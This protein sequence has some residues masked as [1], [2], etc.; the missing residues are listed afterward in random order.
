MA[1]PLVALAAAFY[2]TSGIKSMYKSTAKLGTGYTTNDHIKITDERFNLREADVKFNNLISTMKSELV[3]Y[4]LSYELI[5]HDLTNEVPYRQL[6][7][8]DEN[9]IVL[10]EQDRKRFLEILEKKSNDMQLLSTFDPEENKLIDFMMNYGYLNWQLTEK[11][12]IKRVKN[13]DY[14]TVQFVSENPILSA[15]VV[16]QLSEEYIRYDNSLKENRSG[17]SVTFFKGL[18]DEKKE[19]LD[20]K[21]KALDEYKSSNN[22]TAS[23]ALGGSAVAQIS[24]YEIRRDELN[25]EIQKLNVLIS[26]V[27]YKLNQSG[28]TESRSSI[29]SKI[30]SIKGKI[31]EL[32]NMYN[33]KGGND[34]EL[35]T[36]ID[37]LRYDLRVQMDKLSQMDKNGPATDK[38]YLQG[39]LEKYKLQLRIA[40]TNVSSVNSSIAGLRGGISGMAS[41]EVELNT[42]TQEVDRAREEYLEAQNRYNTERSKS[43]V[44]QSSVQVVVKGQ[45]N[46]NPERSK[47]FILVALAGVASF[48]LCAFVIILL[49]FVDSRLK[50][51][52]YFK[53]FVGLDLL[54]SINQVNLKNLDLK[55][56]FKKKNENEDI[57]TF[58]HFL[59]KLRFELESSDDKKI[60]VTSTKKGEGK[61][62][63]ILCISYILSMINKRIL[64]IDTNFKNN[65]LTNHLIGSNNKM[66]RLENN[67]NIKRLPTASG[68]ETDE[69]VNPDDDVESIISRTVHQG[70]DIIGNNGGENS[71]SEIFVGKDFNTMLDSLATQY[72]YILLEGASLNDFSDSRELVPFVDLVIPVFSAESAIKQE[73]RE[74]LDYLKALN[75]KLKGGILNKI[76]A[77][78]LK[79]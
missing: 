77:K 5:K 22:I 65:S 41:K 34:A 67:F 18:M 57:E 79:V 51:S 17:Q 21:N 11:L 9:A 44:S 69:D 74:S 78:D 75:G 3:V 37:N 46:A 66:K 68:E 54:G 76:L 39:E 50:N 6:K 1:V 42:L 25:S 38:T 32:T 31:D 4:L 28:K 26:D 53:R 52:G 24:Q 19:Q 72:D 63:V 58:K 2:F 70:I 61:T 15:F 16:N 43:L 55:A 12:E 45:P 62:F 10:T 29:N 30:L 20:E 60:L 23:D 27:N 7:Q 13:T 8:D 71:P 14:V 35:K 73:D 56:V 48:A 40:Q 49:E 33:E 36:S 47:R 64:I 59:R